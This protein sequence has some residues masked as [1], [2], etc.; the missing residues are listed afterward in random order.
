MKK[1]ITIGVIAIIATILVPLVIVP[2]FAYLEKFENKEF[3]FSIKYP[4]N[5]VVED[6]VDDRGSDPGFNEGFFSIVY[7]YDDPNFITDSIEV[8]FIKNDNIARN[9]QGQQYLERVESRL[10]EFC[11]TAVMEIDEYECSNFIV[12]DSEITEHKGLPAYKFTH[13]WTERYPDGSSI[14]LK[15][16]LVDIVDGNDVWTIDGISIESEFPRF[17]FTL[18][19]VIESFSLKSNEESSQKISETNSE[20]GGGTALYFDSLYEF[21]FN[22]PSDWQYQEDVKFT[23]DYPVTQVVFFPSE[24]SISSLDESEK[25]LIDLTLAMLGFEFQMDSPLIVIEFENVPRSSVSSLNDQALKD[26]ELEKIIEEAPNAKILN[27]NV[28]NKSWGWV[29]TTE[30]IHN[31]D[32]GIGKP[33]PAHS[34]EKAHYFKDGEIYTVSYVNIGDNYD[35]YYYGKKRLYSDQNGCKT[36]VL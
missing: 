13:T 20:Q 15:S 1:P 11:E 21:S 25:G 2:A 33:L 18:K 12:T 16:I 19:E 8:T 35:K 34:E 14:D 29:V 17:E 26:F 28:E 22:Y 32:L 5:W 9:N 4:E 27:S 3:G 7:F 6:E 23:E 24:F 31:V 10:T 36:I 30:F